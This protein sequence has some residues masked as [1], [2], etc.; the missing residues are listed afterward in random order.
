M[1]ERYPDRIPPA[2]AEVLGMPNFKLE[3]W[4]SALRAVGV[5]VPSRYEG[6]AASALHFLIPFAILHPEDWRGAAI[7]ELQRLKDGGAYVPTVI[8]VAPDD[9]VK[10][11]GA[12]VMALRSYQYGNA[13]PD[14][15]RSI[16]DDGENVLRGLG[17]PTGFMAIESRS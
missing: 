3:P 14:L 12:A 2:L 8:D 10:L 17:F 1:G 11:L 6:E 7:A 5:E 16:A 13:A 9:L 4:W 15:A